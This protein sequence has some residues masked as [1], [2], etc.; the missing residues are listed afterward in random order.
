MGSPWCF[1]GQGSSCEVS[2][3]WSFRLGNMTP[4]MM[5]AMLK[6]SIPEFLSCGHVTWLVAGQRFGCVSG[7]LAWCPCH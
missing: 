2:A 6:R 4:Q 3:F 1:Q 5:L 7:L